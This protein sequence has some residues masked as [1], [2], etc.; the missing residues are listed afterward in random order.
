MA[1]FPDFLEFVVADNMWNRENFEEFLDFLV[2]IPW[3]NSQGEFL[4][5]STGP[6]A[7]S[8]AA[9]PGA[10]SSDNTGFDLQLFGAVE[11]GRLVD[12]TRYRVPG[13]NYAGVP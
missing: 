12:C 8:G 3:M 10:A 13:G 2:I 5:S 9:A 6:G 11:E 1:D 7:V 4:V